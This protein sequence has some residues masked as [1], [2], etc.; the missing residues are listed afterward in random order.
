[1]QVNRPRPLVPAVCAALT[2]I[3]PAQTSFTSPPNVGADGD[4]VVSSLQP[5]NTA[6]G[7]RRFQYIVGDVQDVPGMMG[8]A[9]S[10]V[11]L[12]PDPSAPQSVGRTGNITVVVDHCEFGMLGT[13]F[14]NNYS[15][16]TSYPLGTISLPT[17]TG[18]SGFAIMFTLSAPFQYY[19]VHN[20]TRPLATALLVE[21]RTSS[22]VGGTS[23]SLDC[24]DGTTAPSAGT[25]MYHGLLPCLVPPNT[26]G[27]DI[28]K[29]GPS[30]NGG[31]TTIGHHAL[32]GPASSFGILMFGFTDPNTIYGGL[33]CAPLRTTP[34]IQVP[35]STDAQGAIAN[36][37]NPLLLSFPNLLPVQSLTMYTQ[38]VVADPARQAPQL[39]VSLSDAIRFDLHA[40]TLI[41]RRS[42]YSATSVTAAQGTLTPQ[43]VPVFRFD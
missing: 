29:H 43:F 8:E 16:P 6:T 32:R 35:V 1:M 24:A 38:F 42:L 22:M 33:L 28:F 10:R 36:F 23:Y 13:T 26:G 40:P 30:L 37:A 5:F 4:S 12:R 15:N 27:F 31:F 25:S 2:S 14:A 34:D 20:P 19:G 17:T 3:S 21:F 11:A 7:G 18:A 9:I 41:E 39:G